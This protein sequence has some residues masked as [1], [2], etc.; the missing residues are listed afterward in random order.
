M[1][2]AVCVRESRYNIIFMQT[3]INRI[4]NIFAAAA[5]L[6]P[7]YYTS[8]FFYVHSF[9]AVNTIRVTCMRS[10]AI[11]GGIVCTLKNYVGNGFTIGNTIRCIG[12]EL[13]P[14]EK[15]IYHL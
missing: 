15:N 12:S 4:K 10:K 5:P 8:L 11:S 2:R 6:V 1:W 9:F 14:H 3:Y 7:I 13:E